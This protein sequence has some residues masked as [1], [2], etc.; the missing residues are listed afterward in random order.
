MTP[1]SSSLALNP[2]VES[3]SEAGSNMR[4]KALTV[5]RSARLS[6]KLGTGDDLENT[7]ITSKK[8]KK[9]K[10]ELENNRSEGVMEVSVDQVEFV[11]GLGESGFGCDGETLGIQTV[12]NEKR[13][14]TYSMEMELSLLKSDNEDGEEKGFLNLGCGKDS[15]ILLNSDDFKTD[16]ERNMEEDVCSSWKKK[17]LNRGEKGKWKGKGKGKGKGKVVRKTLLTSNAVSV[18]LEVDKEVGLLIDDSSSRLR[19][20]LDGIDALDQRFKVRVEYRTEN[21]LTGTIHLP[22]NAALVDV[23]IVRETD[24]RSYKKR[25]EQ[26]GGQ[27]YVQRDINSD[28][29]DEE[30]DAN[31]NVRNRGVPARRETRP[32]TQPHVD[33]GVGEGL[34]PLADNRLR[35][36][37]PEIHDQVAWRANPVANRDP[38]EAA[39]LRFYERRNRRDEGNLR[40]KVPIGGDEELSDRPRA[41]T[42]NLEREAE[43]R[44][45]FREG[46]NFDPHNFDRGYNVDRGVNFDR[47]P[48]FQPRDRGFQQ[49]RP[50]GF[51]YSS[52]EEDNFRPRA[53]NRVETVRLIYYCQN[54]SFVQWLLFQCGCCVPDYAI[55]ATLARS[56]NSL[57]VLT[58]V[59]LKGAYRLSDS[60]L[61]ALVSS[62]SSI[63][64]INLVQCSLLTSDG[65]CAL[66]KLENLEVLSLGGIQTVRDKFISVIVSVHGCRIKELCLA[67]CMQLSDLPLKV[68]VATCS[69]LQVIDPSA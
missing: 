51:D 1:S 61:S 67:G 55:S 60:G 56:L 68:T 59:S 9:V 33:P 6:A 39:P 30:E 10:T 45:N 3:R 19:R 7:E 42:K 24:A 8:R 58:T 20:S 63:T 18:R 16:S 66:L 28:S 13:K 37:N 23:N 65:I 41:P 49:R 50:R 34:R 2:G 25:A 57:P 47:G 40:R 29:D 4:S 53:N 48:N 32:I 21:A 43:T 35:Q 17:R 22:E 54:I 69:E 62:A 12:N 38:C 52:E 5:R 26:T 44:F 46:I 36:Q 14:M 64:S 27:K 11:R 15:D 31:L